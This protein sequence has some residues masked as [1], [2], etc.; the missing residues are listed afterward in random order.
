MQSNNFQSTDINEIYALFKAWF[1]LFVYKNH[2]E[3][4]GAQ[5]F[6]LALQECKFALDAPH[7]YDISECFENKHP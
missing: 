1:K 7:T 2:E 4:E 6:S 5:R 3:L